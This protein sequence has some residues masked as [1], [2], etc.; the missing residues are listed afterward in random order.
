MQIRWSILVERGDET[1]LD[2]QADDILGTASVGKLLLLG[3]VAAQ[4]DSGELESTARIDRDT[5]L[6]VGDSGLW[7]LLDQPTL[8]VVDACRLVGA[9]SDNLATNA[10][11]DLVGL[12]CVHAYADRLALRDVA[13]L[14]LV[15]DERD[16]TQPGV[17]ETLS[18]GSARG[19][20]AFMSALHEG[21]VSSRVADWMRL[22]T[23]LSMVAA[24]FGL[25]P[26]AHQGDGLLDKTG[27]D[28]GIRA[29]VGSFGTGKRVDYAV[30]ANWE[31]MQD[32]PAEPI[33]EVLSR[34]REVGLGIRRA[35]GR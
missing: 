9:V 2:E 34:M 17:A 23:D 14:D 7:H 18:I 25:D 30:I 4:L 3:T 1:L 10:L 27:T 19:L 11:L 35:A 12:D 16:P 21:R 20:V 6:T 29:E 26:L 32:A 5:T 31:V 28:D 33:D 8:T 24:A 13:L 22:N 15:R